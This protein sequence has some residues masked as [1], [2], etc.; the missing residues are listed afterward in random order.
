ML[1]VTGGK[2]MNTLNDRYY[3]AHMLDAIEA[4]TLGGAGLLY[5]VV[6]GV[7]HVVAG[8]GWAGKKGLE[9][10]INTSNEKDHT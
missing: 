3:M 10:F 1:R 4:F 7:G 2:G 6:G 5:Y 9:L 8:F